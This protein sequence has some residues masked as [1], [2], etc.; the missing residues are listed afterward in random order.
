MSTREWSDAIIIYF[1]KTTNGN[2]EIVLCYKVK[3]KKVAN[4]LLEM[5][6]ILLSWLFIPSFLTSKFLFSDT[7]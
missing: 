4:F 3:K 6:K 5:N 7:Y 1:I 2:K